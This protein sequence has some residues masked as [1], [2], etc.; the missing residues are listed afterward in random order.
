MIKD[1]Q[2][3][4]D[5]FNSKMDELYIKYQDENDPSYYATVHFDEYANKEEIVGYYLSSYPTEY[6]S[7]FILNL[8]YN[9]SYVSDNDIDIIRILARL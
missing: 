4:I 6:L 7:Q 9:A 2:Y 8:Y 5:L 3:Y 1:K